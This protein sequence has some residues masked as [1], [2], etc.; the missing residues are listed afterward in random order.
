LRR[1]FTHVEAVQAES[2]RTITNSRV[3]AKMSNRPHHSIGNNVVRILDKPTLQ[4]LLG[5]QRVYDI[6]TGFHSLPQKDGQLHPGETTSDIELRLTFA[7]VGVASD[8]A[9]NPTP[10][11]SCGVQDEVP[12]SVILWVQA[13]PHLRVVKPFKAAIRPLLKD[14]HPSNDLLDKS[15]HGVILF[16]SPH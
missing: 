9:Y 16:R 1:R 4:H 14:C 10:K 13:L 15:T 7:S 2:N 6:T 3:N 5:W 11:A 8:S 12:Y